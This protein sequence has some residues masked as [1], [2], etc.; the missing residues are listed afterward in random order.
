MKKIY[1]LGAGASK[2]NTQ[3]Q[4]PLISE[5]FKYASEYNILIDY[6]ERIDEFSNIRQFVQR[7]YGE[8][9]FKGKFDGDIEEILTTIQIEK[10]RG[11]NS[12]ID[13]V[14]RELLEIIQSVLRSLSIEVS[15]SSEY[16]KLVGLVDTTDTILTYNWDNMLDR[17]FF[18]DK[19]KKQYNR[20]TWKF[21]ALSRN[22]HQG[23]DV[24]KPLSRIDDKNGY[25][26]KLHGSI[27][28]YSCNNPDCELNG[29]VFILDDYFHDQYCSS[30]FKPISPLLIPP[31][32]NKTYEKF[33][34]INRIWGKAVN[35][36]RDCEELIIWGYSLPP[37]DFH[38]KWLMKNISQRVS[39]VKVIDPMCVSGRS[40]QTWNN[41]FRRKFSKL[42]NHVDCQIEYFEY[43]EDYLTDKPA[44]EKYLLSEKDVRV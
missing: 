23:Y 30:C 42:F 19:T 20:F 17:A 1:V 36:M 33:P 44:L 5:F 3:G 27:D 32:L 26:L 15:Q 37:T 8:D 41:D 2:S 16:K 24:V 10:V 34:V 13:S 4:F 28:W 9:I 43:F 14:E 35:E 6:P 40:K 11:G 39:K 22:Q 25:F 7:Y 21:T 12:R 31:V 18:S 29:E 38:S